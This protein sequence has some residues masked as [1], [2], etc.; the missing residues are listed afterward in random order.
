[1]DFGRA[2]KTIRGMRR[3]SQ[4]ELAR[5]A[6]LDPSYVSFIESGRRK[7]SMTMAEE[8]ARALGVPIYLF[9]LIGSDKEDLRGIAPD[10][11][12]ALGRQLLELLLVSE[13][14]GGEADAARAK[15][16]T[17]KA[18]VVARTRKT[19]EHSAKRTETD[20]D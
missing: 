10:H 16:R 7:P 8:L 2:V 14:E 18:G 9:M 4:G 19:P 15:T 5:R 17:K 12:G 6:D 13:S 3:M 11:A 20:R 1:M